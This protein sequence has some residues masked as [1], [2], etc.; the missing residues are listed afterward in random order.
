MIGGLKPNPI[1]FPIQ[2]IWEI[3]LPRVGLSVMA[4]GDDPNCRRN[5]SIDVPSLGYAGFRFGQMTND[6]RDADTADAW[7]MEGAMNQRD[8]AWTAAP[9]AGR[10]GADYG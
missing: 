1:T 7:R 3:R 4:I 2:E 6:G 8:S 5:R 9:S 10:R